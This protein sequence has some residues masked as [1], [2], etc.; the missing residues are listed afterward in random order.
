L[1][2][3]LAQQDEIVESTRDALKAEL[4]EGGM[5]RL[6]AHVEREKR[7]MKVAKEDR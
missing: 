3:F 5:A 7:N 4:S 2:G 1:A 6:Q